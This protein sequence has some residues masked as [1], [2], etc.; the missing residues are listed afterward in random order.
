MSIDIANA[1][2]PDLTT[3]AEL[4]AGDGEHIEAN[5]EELEQSHH[6]EAN[7]ESQESSEIANQRWHLTQG[8]GQTPHSAY[9]AEIT[10]PR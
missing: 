7:E 3:L 9:F 5:I 1:V 8:Q 6:G 2:S 10:S 4:R